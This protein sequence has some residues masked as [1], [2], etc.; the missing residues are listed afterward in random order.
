VVEPTS[1]TSAPL[2]SIDEITTCYP[3]NVGI[4]LRAGGFLVLGTSGTYLHRGIT[5]PDGHCTLDPEKDPLLTSRPASIGGEPPLVF[6]NP[7]VEFTMAPEL[8]A[9]EEQALRN[10]SVQVRNGSAGLQVTSVGSSSSTDALPAA[11]RYDPQLGQ[12]Y[13][14]DTASQGL[15]RYLLRP[16]EFDT[17]SFH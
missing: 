13:L 4:E 16:F 17:D 11:L 6:K 9:N 2:R 15:R 10:T 7:Y 3:D 8:V 5:G 12:L 14:L 1:S